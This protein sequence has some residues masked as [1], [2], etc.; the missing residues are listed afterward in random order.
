ML[1]AARGVLAWMRGVERGQGA[2]AGF[3]RATEPAERRGLLL[4]EF[5]FEQIGGMDSLT[6]RGLL[7]RSCHWQRPVRRASDS[8]SLGLDGAALIG[9]R[10]CR[11]RGEAQWSRD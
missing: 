9:L 3:E 4:G 6:W 10:L 7:V 8:S 5:V 2:S 11:D 1:R